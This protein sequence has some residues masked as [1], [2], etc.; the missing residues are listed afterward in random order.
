VSASG[1]IE[2][3]R[4]V[5]AIDPG[6]VLDPEI[7]VSAIEGGTAW[8]LSCAM[9]SEITFAR[10]RTEQTNFHDYSI[11]RMPQMPPVEV[12]LINSGVLPLGG[13]GEIGPV[14]VIP[15]LTNAIFA[16]TGKRLRSL[17]LSRHGLTLA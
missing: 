13:T 14:T 3:H 6:I 2:I 5:A 16:A 8:G 1:A 17:P 4:V 11:L 7:T 9:T 10:G 15:A 12:H